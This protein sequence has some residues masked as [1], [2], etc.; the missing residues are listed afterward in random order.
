MLTMEI[1]HLSNPV[2]VTRE[3][4]VRHYKKISMMFLLL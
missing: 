2:W 1:E 4:K 3:M